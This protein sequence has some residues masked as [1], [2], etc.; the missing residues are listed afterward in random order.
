VLLGQ[1]HV[2][3]YKLWCQDDM[4]HCKNSLTPYELVTTQNCDTR[5]PQYIALPQYVSRGQQ[6]QHLSTLTNINT[7]DKRPAHSYTNSPAAQCAG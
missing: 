2:R 3:S 7:A 6:Q 1:T 4:V 5:R